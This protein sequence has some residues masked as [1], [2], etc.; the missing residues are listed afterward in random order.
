MFGLQLRTLGDAR[1]SSALA[2]V[3]VQDGI[4]AQ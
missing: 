4:K 1:F 2:N 3:A